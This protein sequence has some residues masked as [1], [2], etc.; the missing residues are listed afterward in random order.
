MWYNTVVHT[1]S[2]TGNVV[3]PMAEAIATLCQP[4]VTCL[5]QR[6]TALHLAAMAGHVA[7]VETLLLNGADPEA[8]DKHVR[9]GSLYK[10]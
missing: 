10:S 2:H 1:C 6:H 3:L 4:A 8:R 9:F 7:V 5:L